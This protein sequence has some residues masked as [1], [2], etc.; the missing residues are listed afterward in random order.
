MKSFSNKDNQRTETSIFDVELID[1]YSRAA[2]FDT[3][4]WTDFVNSYTVLNI[5]ASFMLSS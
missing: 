3:E 2:G 5:V 4:L 1:T